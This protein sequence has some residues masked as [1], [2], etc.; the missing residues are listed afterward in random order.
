MIDNTKIGWTYY[1][2]ITVLHKN[3][4]LVIPDIVYTP[5]EDGMYFRHKTCQKLGI[6]KPVKVLKV[7]FL[8]TMGKAKVY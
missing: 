7:E 6:Q 1:A 2:N 4:R 3:E 5:K 8:R